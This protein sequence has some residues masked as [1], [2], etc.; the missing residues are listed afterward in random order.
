MNIEKLTAI[1]KFAELP[2]TEISL[3][4]LI[5][6]RSRAVVFENMPFQI[7]NE[8]EI[9]FGDR[10]SYGDKS[11][12][13][14]RGKEIK[15]RKTVQKEKQEVTEK[16]SKSP[17]KEVNGNIAKDVEIRFDALEKEMEHER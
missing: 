15:N 6:K 1:L 9:S 4:H 3:K 2:V 11:G 8:M 17:E 10:N 16:N 5:R 14:D 12:M 13:G 7:R